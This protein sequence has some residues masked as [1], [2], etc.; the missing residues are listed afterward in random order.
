MVSHGRLS[1]I[2][3]P[4][5]EVQLVVRQR[6]LLFVNADAHYSSLVRLIESSCLL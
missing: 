3:Q 5:T 4:A 1:M 6:V 2:D